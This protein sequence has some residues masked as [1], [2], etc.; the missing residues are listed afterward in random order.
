MPMSRN[1][2]TY[3][4]VDRVLRAARKAGNAR[5][6]LPTRGAAV[7]WRMR[8]YFYRKLLTDLAR[9]RAGR[10]PGFM[11]TTDFDDM[12]V[13]VEPKP[14]TAVKI[15]FTRLPGKLT[16]ESGN[17]LVPDPS[18]IN[19]AGPSDVERI[20]SQPAREDVEVVQLEESDLE[21]QARE[22]VQKIDK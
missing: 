12:F 13:E 5:Y 11:P 20:L 2:N 18:H 3:A 16:D 6:E 4:D 21:R 1:I 22:L 9:T 14:S 17:E 10:V 8:A 19:P 15:T 7:N